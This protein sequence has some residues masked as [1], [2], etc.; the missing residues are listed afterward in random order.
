[1]S[2]NKIIFLEQTKIPTHY[3]NV[4]A[5]VDVPMAPYLHPGTRQPVTPDLLTPL[6]PMEIIK[7]EVTTERF[8]EIPDEV[9]DLYKVSRPT[10]LVRAD[11]LE[12]V[13]NT[14]AKIYFKYEGVN[15]AG[16]HKTNTSIPQAYYNKK[17]GIKKITTETGAGQWGSALS[18]ACN[19]FGLEC[20]VFMVK[21]SYQ[22]KPYRRTFMKLF[23][24]SVH[25][26]PSNLTNAG[27]AILE[28]ALPL[29]KRL[30]L[31]HK[32]KIHITVLAAC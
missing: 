19:H 10:P 31:Q 22:Q 26:S 27:R 14:P 13:L 17:E 15:P 9:R 28:K 18:Y 6:F 16:S 21:I 8:I 25:E 30:N 29:V 23:G 7:Q 1:M 2:K 3:Y 20:E 4:L 5:D 11:G 32:E 24:A 12:K